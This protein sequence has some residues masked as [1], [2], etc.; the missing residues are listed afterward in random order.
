MPVTSIKEHGRSMFALGRGMLLPR[1]QQRP[2]NPRVL[3]SDVT[4]ALACA[5]SG[6]PRR[7]DGGQQAPKT[8]GDVQPASGSSKAVETGGQEKQDAEAVSAALQDAP[9][10]QHRVPEVGA[11]RQQVSRD[12]GMLS[13]IPVELSTPKVRFEAL[14]PSVFCKCCLFATSVVLPISCD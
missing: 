7:R 9:S 4:D 5:I 6:Q 1:L 3:N 11:D 12:W 2:A 10:L 13:D 14:R 8:G